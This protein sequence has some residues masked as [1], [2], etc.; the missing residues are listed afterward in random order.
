MVEKQQKDI[1]KHFLSSLIYKNSPLLHK[2]LL[3]KCFRPELYNEVH[4]LKLNQLDKCQYLKEKLS[5]IRHKDSFTA[6]KTPSNLRVS[7]SKDE[8]KTE[9]SI[10]NKSKHFV[11]NYIRTIQSQ[12]GLLL[13]NATFIAM[14][15][16]FIKRFKMHEKIIQKQMNF[17]LWAF[18]LPANVVGIFITYLFRH[19]Y[20][21]DLKAHYQADI[22][23]YK[24]LFN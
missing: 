4:S 18:I 11:S 12:I 13:V 7:K 9:I 10:Q 20:E 1:D 19:P 8:E 21:Y 22:E 23:K 5:S 15:V 14:N 24:V 2:V 6:I 16:Y 3:D 17:T